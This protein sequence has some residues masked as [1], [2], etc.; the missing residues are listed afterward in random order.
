M[1]NSTHIKNVQ[2]CFCNALLIISSGALL[3]FTVAER[4]ANPTCARGW[5]AAAEIVEKVHFVPKNLCHVL[6]LDLLFST[7]HLRFLLL[8][9][10][11]H[12]LASI[13]TPVIMHG[14]PSSL[15]CYSVSLQH[16][17]NE[18]SQHLLGLVSGRKAE[19]V[20]RCMSIMPSLCCFACNA[21]WL[22]F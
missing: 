22:L 14:T 11:A 12:M 19:R 21:E 15:R 17:L 16:K 20:H 9:P 7:L 2:L 18:L 4:R 13:C 8:P 5:R 1:Y 10:K 6:H 3:C